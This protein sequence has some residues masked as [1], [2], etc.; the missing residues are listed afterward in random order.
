MASRS[1]K[2]RKLRR[3]QFLHSPELSVYTDELTEAYYI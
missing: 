3:Y 2:I 1:L